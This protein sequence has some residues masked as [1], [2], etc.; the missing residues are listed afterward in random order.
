MLIT[1]NVVDDRK[2]WS[3]LPELRVLIEAYEPMEKTEGSVAVEGHFST[4]VDNGP[5]Y[6]M[7]PLKN[8]IS[9]QR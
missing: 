4:V 2:R 1:V 9:T 7:F 8:H 3:N 6:F 5:F